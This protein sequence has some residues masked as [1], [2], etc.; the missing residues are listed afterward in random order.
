MAL[1]SP[2]AETFGA[3]AGAFAFRANTKTVPKEWLRQSLRPPSF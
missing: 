1:E 3:Q 2:P